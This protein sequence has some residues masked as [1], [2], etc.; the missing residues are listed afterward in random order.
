[1]ALT[2][3]L[4]LGIVGVQYGL[5]ARQLTKQVLEQTLAGH[6]A[7]AAVVNRLYKSPTA[8]PGKTWVSCSSMLLRGR[9]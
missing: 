4:T 8:G 6:Q 7:D 9:G 2:L 3:L 1:L 5:A